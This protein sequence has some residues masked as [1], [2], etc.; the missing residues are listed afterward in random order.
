MFEI[1]NSSNN[2][3]AG[4]FSI[5]AEGI[6]SWAPHNKFTISSLGAI[7]FDEEGSYIIG[8]MTA[9]K[10]LFLK[11]GNDGS[12]AFYDFAVKY[13][14][15]KTF[16]TADLEGDW[17]AVYIENNRD[18]ND[19]SEAGYV[20]NITFTNTGVAGGSDEKVFYIDGGIL[21]TQ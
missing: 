16:T 15:S 18:D 13:D 3:S 11:T 7:S 6:P 17:R 1:G 12:S 14:S 9:N 4:F 10:E 2:H 5:N 21:L 8:H 19:K 20:E